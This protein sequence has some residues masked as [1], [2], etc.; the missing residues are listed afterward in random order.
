MIEVKEAYPLKWP[1][2]WPRVR[3]QDRKTMG[4]WKGNAN[5]YREALEKELNRMEAPSFV[6]SC[7]VQVSVRGSM[8]Q[9]I[10]PL[11]PGVAVYFSRKEK[12]DFSWQDALEIHDPAPS[13][14]QVQEAFKRLASLYHPDKIGGDRELFLAATKHRDNALRWIHRKTNQQYGYV[15]AC[16]QFKEVRLNLAAIVQTIKSIRNIE[17]CGTSSLM[18]KAWEGFGALPAYTGATTESGA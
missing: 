10:E 15:I 4:T 2:S 14:Q 16:D 1:G 12:E 13:E 11:D 6:V 5:K 7:N 17:R 3:P 9:G 18:E 8:T